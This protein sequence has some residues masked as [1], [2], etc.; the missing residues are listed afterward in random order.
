LA[1]S[2]P[3]PTT[4]TQVEPL[5]DLGQQPLTSVVGYTALYYHWADGLLPWAVAGGQVVGDLASRPGFQW[6][7][8]PLSPHTLKLTETPKDSRHGTT[9]QVKLQGERPQPTPNVLA[10]MAALE[11]RPLVALVRQ[12][13]GQL[14]LV[15]T[16]EAPL[17]LLPAGQGQHPGTRAGLDLLLSTLTDALAPFYAGALSVGGLDASAPVAP[18]GGGHVR[19]LNGRDQ[20]QLVAP[21]G[22]DLIIEGPFRVELRLR[23]TV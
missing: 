23:P 18:T 10:A 14:R 16:R 19:V 21:A 12:A 7:L 8:L 5:L 17:R 1:Q 9:Y 3:N 4:P 15:G 13:D 22:Y 20:L 6:Q 2:T 11:R